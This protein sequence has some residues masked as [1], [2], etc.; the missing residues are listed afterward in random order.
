ME[1]RPVGKPSG[2]EN[3]KGFAAEEAWQ[4]QATV[5]RPKYRV[6]RGNKGMRGRVNLEEVG[7]DRSWRVGLLCL[8]DLGICWRV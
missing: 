4:I 5:K 7:G 8:A 3:S 1:R 2:T 6:H